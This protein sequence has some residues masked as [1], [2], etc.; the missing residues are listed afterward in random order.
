MSVGA[1]ALYTIAKRGDMV[2]DNAVL[3]DQGVLWLCRE[4][5]EGR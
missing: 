4:I 1:F 5:Y 3:V 2:T